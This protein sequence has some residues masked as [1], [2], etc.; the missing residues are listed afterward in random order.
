MNTRILHPLEIS[1]ATIQISCGNRSGTGFF[2]ASQNDEFVILTCDHNLSDDHPVIVLLKNVEVE[3]QI[4]ERNPERDVAL[5]RVKSESIENVNILPLKGQQIP[6]DEVWETYGF[7]VQ[8]VSTGGRY[9]GRVSRTNDGTKWDVDLECEQYTNLNRFDGLSGSAL[10]IDGYAVGVIGYDNAG[11]LGATSIKSILALLNKYGIIVRIEN[12]GS[13]PDSIERDIASTT[14]NH[15]VLQTLSSVIREQISGDYFLISGSPGSGKT[16]IAAQLELDEQS[17]VIV[18]RF[19]VKVPEGDEYPTQIRANPDFFIKW[20]E[21]VC[22]RTILN[23]P[24]PKKKSEQTLGD[25]IVE[26]HHLLKQM[27]EHF[28]QQDKIGFLIVDGLDDVSR[29]KI[30]DY[31]LVLPL[32]LPSNVK[33]IFSCTSREILPITLQANIDVSREIKI[34]PLPIWNAEKFLNEQLK[35]KELTASQITELAQKSEGHPL[36]LRYLSQIILNMDNVPSLD[37]WIN[38]IPIIGGEIR[39]YYTKI[40][41]QMVENAEEVWLAATLSRLRIPVDKKT[42]LH[43]VPAESSHNFLK[44]FNKIRHLIRND[45]AISIYHTSFSDYVNDVTTTFSEQVHKNIADFIKSHPKDDFSLSERIY[46]LSHGNVQCKKMAVEEC[47]Q[48]W[49]DDCAFNSVNPDIVLADVKDVIGLAA[50]LGIAHKVISLL[51]LS[52]RVNFRYNTLFQENATFL[53]SALLALRKPQEALRYVVRNKTLI[54]SD[55][56]ALYLLQQFYEHDAAEEAE[57]LLDAIN[58]TCTSIMESGFDS[59][60]FNRFISLKFSAVT[61]SSNSDFQ[62]SFGEFDHIKKV[63]LKIIEGS[64]NSEEAVHKFKDDVG[65]YNLGYFIWRFNLPS[66]S[67]KIEEELTSFKFDDRSSGYLA[68]GIY[69]ALDFQEKSPKRKTADNLSD[70]I[71]DL[72]YVIDKYGTHQDYYFIL[73]YVLL[74]RSK[75]LDIIERLFQHLYP[76]AKT[77]DIREKNGV[78]LNHQSIHQFS[79][80]SECLG[81]FDTTEQFTELP[82]YGFAFEHWEEDIKRVFQYLCF[83]SGKVKRYRTNEDDNAIKSLHTRLLELV[84]KLIPD[85]RYRMHWKRS[86]ALPE[87]MFPIIYKI[88]VRLFIDAFPNQIQVFIDQIVEKKHYQ[89]GLY[90]EGYTDSLF[91]IAR[92]LAKKT[93]HSVSAFKTLKILEEHVIATVENRWERNEYLLRLVEL[94][95]LLENEDRAQSVFKEMIDTSMGPSWYKEAQLG[96]INAA[97]SNIVPSGGDFSYL[98]NFAANL[99]SASGE[100]TFQRYVKQQQEEFVGDLAKIGFLNKSIAYFKYLLLPDHQ[101]I[102]SNAESGIVDMPSL[103]KGYVLGAKAIEEQS[104]I[105]DMLLNINCKG[106]LVAWALSELFILGDNRYLRS[107]ATLQSRILNYIEAN[108]PEKLGVVLKRFARFTVSEIC[109]EYRYEYLRELFS[110]LTDS[111]L[112]SAR[113]YLTSV[114]M[115]P[116]QAD[117][118]EEDEREETRASTNEEN[119]PLIVARETAKTQL[120]TEN[121]S[122]ARKTIIEA[123]TEVQNQKHGIWSSNYDSRV[124]EVRNLLSGSYNNS[125]ELVREIRGLIINEPYFEEWVIANQLIQILRNINDEQ[126]KQFILSA[127]REHIELM[128]RTPRSIYEKYTWINNSSEKASLTDNDDQLLELLIW[129]LNHPSLVVK[130]RTIEILS[131]LGSVMPEFIIQALINEILSEG[132]KISKE[133]SASIIHQISNIKTTGLGQKMKLAFEQNERELLKI[134]HLMI[135]DSLIRSLKAQK[136]QGALDLD[137]LIAKFENT[138]VSSS[139]PGGDIEFDEPYLDPIADYLYELNDLAIL[140]KQFAIK[141]LDLIPKLAPLAIDESQK[142]SGYIDRSF[143]DHFDVALISDFDTVLRYALNVAVYSCT[144]IE[145]SDYVAD[146]LRFYQPTFPENSLQANFGLRDEQFEVAIRDFFETGILDFDK[147]SIKGELPLNYLSYIHTDDTDGEKIDMTAYLVPLNKFSSNRRSFPQ[148]SFSAN[149]YPTVISEGLKNVIPLFV[150]SK[151]A[152]SVT[153]GELV[154]ATINANISALVPDIVANA[155]TVYWREG[156]NWDKQRQ[157]VAQKNGYFTTI[158]HEIIGRLKSEYK[159]IW[160]IYKGYESKYIDVFEQM[161]IER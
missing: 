129:F 83:L 43:L 64:G 51:L 70:W 93:E 55:G 73:L 151:N 143:N 161:E 153:G 89:L 88:L 9:N 106:S 111:N 26:I 15:E 82:K 29:S 130:N 147:M 58:R 7:P 139:K 34:T 19:F 90:T 75:R 61:L 3:A 20:V 128:V 56:D 14:P 37:E 42:L 133:L 8:R 11:T 74:G 104:G 80:F 145:N 115:K 65:S 137:T 13:I 48:H 150:N 157:G 40:W 109:D 53:V 77:L 101:T 119:D 47:N 87:S 98:Q 113:E 31:L 131:W 44:N 117:M 46:H 71:E 78:D 140:T 62:N 32:T 114:G 12:G 160:R 24:P 76:E 136:E 22:Y 138:F 66:Y 33:V 105:L 103:G 50:D 69:H 141:L 100:M 1:E 116:S 72:E 125:E 149:S 159:L 85:L 122:A 99:H 135:R 152:S 95:A 39:N 79:L 107:Y 54:T 49:I 27:S 60:S 96:L 102:I 127:V 155:K 132:Y 94:Y 92:E 121:K 10:V 45:E 16:T 41:L 112:E 126:E 52:Q 110:K 30:E 120:D 6:Y 25:R 84:E 156:R 91:I 123:L 18:D 21:E 63:T 17:Y 5:L 81:F 148:L 108:E 142:A 59:A 67:K 57:V 4:L 23:L 35:E 146:I 134:E 68:W 38:S 144:T 36:Y 118:K 154:P 2:I 158:S 97:I 28:Q 124:N 86:Y